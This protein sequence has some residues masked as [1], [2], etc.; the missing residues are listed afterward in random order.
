MIILTLSQLWET[1]TLACDLMASNEGKA[2]RLQAIFD[3]LPTT[4]KEYWQAYQ[5]GKLSLGDIENL[6]YVLYD[7]ELI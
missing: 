6:V 2:D 1:E 5:I 7:S 3:D 4:H